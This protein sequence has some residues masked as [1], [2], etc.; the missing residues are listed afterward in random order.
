MGMKLCV[1]G[2]AADKAETEF[3]GMSAFRVFNQAT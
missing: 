3:V 2:M 1:I